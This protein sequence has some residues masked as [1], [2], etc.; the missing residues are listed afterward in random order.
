M[1][2]RVLL[3]LTV[4]T[5]V[6]CNNAGP[7]GPAGADGATG[8][9]GPA[10]P[11]GQAGQNGTNGTNGMNG[12]TGT[13]GTNGRSSLVRTA[14]EPAGTNCR[15]GG[16]AILVGLDTDNDGMLADTEVT[17]RT[18]V[19]GPA[20]Q[21]LVRVAPENPGANCPLGGV[22][23]ASGAD[24]NADGVLADTEITTR[25]YVCGQSVAD[26]VIEGSVTIRN[27][28]DYRIY[29]QVRRITGTLTIGQG[30]DTCCSAV[31]AGPA[32]MDFPNLE[33]VGRLEMVNVAGVEQLSFPRLTGLTMDGASFDMGEG[34][35]LRSHVSNNPE[36]R[37]FTM[38]LL[39]T[40]AH[41]IEVNS[42]PLYVEC[43]LRAL[44]SQ[45]ADN[46]YGT[47]L[48]VSQNGAA[49]PDA[50][51][52]C[53]PSIGC[54]VARPSTPWPRGRDGGPQLPDSLVDAGTVTINFAFC[55]TRVA[56]GDVEATCR[57]LFDGGTGV[58]AKSGL[59][60]TT[61]R[62][63]ATTYFGFD[64]VVLGAA[65]QHADGG[66]TN[67]DGG[68][69]WND[70]APLDFTNW[71]SSEPNGGSNE[72]CLQQYSSGLWNDATCT[73]LDNLACQVP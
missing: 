17:S 65:D 3:T 67:V 8:P 51:A 66:V 70:G 7:Q 13:N 2:S 68:W 58:Y 71:E 11:M 49:V 32:V 25:N 30:S 34:G 1:T 41:Q 27:D 35:Q 46:G 26:V 60:N 5:L 48:I 54:W 21:T 16:T 57:S 12:S 4:V 62:E 69:A 31:I 45:L 20:S 39:A 55:P 42:N 18:Y 9:Q 43:G 61:L 6:S 10:G 14:T 56:R 33:R 24:T 59:I 19:C 15:N 63:R 28:V 44:W 52:V 73:G 72:N 22:L 53:A 38:P 47:D 36:L 64:S 29:R 23:V 40:L 50:G 37:V